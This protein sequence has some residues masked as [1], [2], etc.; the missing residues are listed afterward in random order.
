MIRWVALT[1]SAIAFGAT[2]TSAYAATT[3]AEYVAQVDPI[4]ESTQRPIA[5]AFVVL[6]KAEAR[7]GQA[8][9]K[10][11]S[12]LRDIHIDSYASCPDL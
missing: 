12:S 6:G 7:R 9:R 2:V 8:A 11:S 3:R 5:K 4:C 1:V 10:D